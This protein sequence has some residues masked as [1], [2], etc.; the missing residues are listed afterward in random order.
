MYDPGSNDSRLEYVELYNYTNTPI[1][2][3]DE[4]GIPWR[5]TAGMDYSFP[6]NTTI[7]PFSYMIVVKDLD[8]FENTYDVGNNATVLG[9]FGGQLSDGGA[10][11]LSQPGDTDEL[12]TQYFIRLDRVRYDSKA[13]WPPS[14]DGEGDALH[15]INRTAYGNDATNWEGAAPSPGE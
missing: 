10:L 4:E 5:F 8:A 13:P 2:L 14:A 15:R 11:V 12:G 6:A 3:Y 9:P 1:A 7:A